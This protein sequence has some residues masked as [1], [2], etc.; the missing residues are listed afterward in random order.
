MFK[1]GLTLRQRRFRLA[2]FGLVALSVAAPCALIGGATRTSCLFAGASA[3]LVLCTLYYVD[4]RTFL[5]V[6]ERGIC[7]SSPTMAV[8]I[9]YSKVSRILV[10]VWKG[11]VQAMSVYTGGSRGRTLVMEGLSDMEKILDLLKQRMPAGVPVVTQDYGRGLWCP[12]ALVLIASVSAALIAAFVYQAH[13][14]LNSDLATFAAMYVVVFAAIA[15]ALTNARRYR[16]FLVSCLMLA[17]AITVMAL[18]NV[19]T[20]LLMHVIG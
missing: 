9:D 19:A 16:S 1:S 15:G 20:W 5:L 4:R 6:A 2:Y 13:V 14:R 8:G 7:L 17:A 3:A 12:V 10:R 11:H 18:L